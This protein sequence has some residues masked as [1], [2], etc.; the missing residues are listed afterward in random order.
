MRPG[1]LFMWPATRFPDHTAVVFKDTRLTFAQ[2]EAR[3]NQVTNGLLALGLCTGHKVAVLLN[4]GIESAVTLLAIPRAGLT[5]ISLNARHTSAEHAY[6]LN[7]G[8]VLPEGPPETLVA[9]DEVREVYLG[10]HFSL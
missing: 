10:K 4:N 1:I 2:F 5:Y 7:D 9:N 8:T 3:V 6:I